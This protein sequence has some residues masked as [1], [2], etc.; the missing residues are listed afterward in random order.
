MRWSCASLVV[1]ACVLACSSTPSEGD[2]R[3]RDND[4]GGGDDGGGGGS[5]DGDVAPQGP[6]AI[7]FI[8]RFDTRDPAGP[9]AAWPGTRIVIRF[10]GTDV[11]VRFDDQFDDGKPGP[12]EWDAT[13]D[14]ALQPKLP[15]VKGPHDYDVAKGLAPGVHVVELYKRS[16]SQVGVTQLLGVDVHGGTLLA[17]PP[18]SDRRVEIIGDSAATGFGVDGVGPSCPGANDAAMYENFR[19]SWGATL[20]TLF[21]ADVHGTTYSGKGL[22]KDIWRPDTVV[23]PLLFPR[24]NP[25]D[26]TS[27]QDLGAW[28]P[29]VVVVMIGG[30]DFDVGLPVD[31]GPATLDDFTTAYKTLAMTLRAAYPDA[32]L[33]LAPS[34]TLSD[35]A[36]MGRA[37]RT[38]VNAAIASVVASRAAAGDPRVHAVEPS[39]ATSAETTGCDGHGGR[40]FHVRVA[41]ELAAVIGPSVGWK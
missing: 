13:I 12:S 1:G 20:G 24:A 11:T 17:P 4:A 25:E 8:G 40:A 33:F 18:A 3:T 38:N 7:G 2:A 10:R 32:Q 23:M 6:P 14:G 30:N 35:D 37:S 15:L 22:V 39:L 9:K 28:R 36:P 16:E 21:R 34:P 19:E 5:V 27:I 31:D 29:H 41:G 26:D